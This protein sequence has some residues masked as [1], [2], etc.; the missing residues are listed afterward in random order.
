MY[1]LKEIIRKY[2]LSAN[3]ALGQNFILDTQILDKL[4]RFAVSD[5]NPQKILEIGPGPGGLTQALLKNSKADLTVVE[6]DRRCVEALQELSSDFPNRLTILEE[7]ALKFDETSMGEKIVLASNLPY[8]ISTVLFVKWLKQIS[9]FSRLSLMFQKEVADRLVAQPH[10][11]AYGR[12][13]VL[14]QWLCDVDILMNLNPAIFTPAPKVT[15]TFLSLTPKEKPFNVSFN[16][17]EKVTAVA[18]GQRRKM[19]RGSLK[20][21]GN[22][23]LLCEVAGVSE[24]AR[25]EEVSVE[26]FCLMAKKWEELN[27][28]HAGTSC[29]TRC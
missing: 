26:G 19:L 8:N 29:P 2:G 5:K 23:S 6:K 14:T 16:A 24:T 17:M 4:A 13:S 18:F 10:D 28:C 9:R 15:S 20:K 12:L 11:K 1:V 3:K 7:D 25:A 27:G 22:P 21:L